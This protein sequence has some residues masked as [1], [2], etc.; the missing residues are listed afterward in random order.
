MI[1]ACDECLGDA[2]YLRAKAAL[3]LGKKEECNAESLI[4]NDS[5]FISLNRAPHTTEDVN[6]GVGLSIMSEAEKSVLSATVVDQ[7]NADEGE[8]TSFEPGNLTAYN[9]MQAVTDSLKKLDSVQAG[10]K[11]KHD[12]VVGAAYR[13]IES[14]FIGN[15]GIKVAI[16]STVPEYVIVL[17]DANGL[18]P[19][20]REKIIRLR[21]A[22]KTRL[23]L[24][25]QI[26]WQIKMFYIMMIIKTKK[27]FLPKLYSAR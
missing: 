7:H 27:A 11:K 22:W 9:Y 26:I 18:V 16:I 10:S 24:H 19:S 14:G 1:N 21:K 3:L 23:I 13:T 6:L 20:F 2:K 5:A 8:I 12:L 17:L 4:I 25:W 15:A